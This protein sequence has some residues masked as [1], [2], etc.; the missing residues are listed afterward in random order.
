M[1]AIWFRRA[2]LLGSVSEVVGY[3]SGLAL[4]R[5]EIAQHTP[6]EAHLWQGDDDERIRVRSEEFEELVTRLLYEVGNIRTPRVVFPSIALYHKFKRDREKRELVP[7]ILELFIEIFKLDEKDGLSGDVD[8]FLLAALKRHGPKGFRVALEFVSNI[9]NWF[10]VNPWANF[11]RYH[12]KNTTELRELFE[13][14]SLETL[15][16]DF[17]DQRFIDY[18]DRNFGAIDSINWRKFEGLAAEFFAREGYHVNIGPGRDD[19]NIDV[20]VWP[21]SNEASEPPTM[22]IQ[23]KREKR[24]VGK[25]VVKALWADIQDEK[26][27]SGLIVTT[28]AL[29]P[30]AEK[31]RLA[32]SY[33][34]QQAPRPTIQGW[35]RRMRT[36]SQG[37]FLGL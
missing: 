12:W 14:E 3:K 32:R 21:S 9:Q 35:I 26:A 18:L 27:K 16:G 29:S 5:E 20:R 13:S 36:P 34:I 8:S 30:G 7:K 11:R 6:E 31:V 17:L 19:G 37:V 1:G 28:T 22:L 25:I 33:P 10:H 24:K 23:C 2:E 15:Y 4:T